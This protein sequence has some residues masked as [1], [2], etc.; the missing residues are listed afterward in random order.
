M[1]VPLDHDEKTIVLNCKYKTLKNQIK[2]FHFFY[3]FPKFMAYF[4]VK[5]HKNVRLLCIASTRTTFSQMRTLQSFRT[6]TTNET[7]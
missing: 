5:M 4:R 3:A 7:E 2:R 6:F 1:L